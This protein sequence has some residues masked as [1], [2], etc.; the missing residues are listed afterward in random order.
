MHRYAQTNIQ[1]INQLLREGYGT[2][3]VCAVTRAYELCAVLMT[4]RFRASGKTFIA[5][6]VGTAS[7]LGSL[8]APPALIAAGLLHAVYLAGDFGGD[9]LP[10]I[11]DAKRQRVRAAVGEQVENYV[12]RYDA[13]RWTDHSIR[14]LSVALDS[15]AAT[16]RDIVLV[17]LANELE[18]HLDL[19]ILYCA[20]GRR[21]Q[22][23]GEGRCRIMVAMAEGLGF[24][25]LAAELDRAFAEVAAAS[26]PRELLGLD[27]HVSSFLIAPQ[28]YQ[29]LKD[30]IARRLASVS[31]IRSEPLP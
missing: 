19:G 3:D 29:Q 14:V 25:A 9:G 4:G 20:D 8:Q 22:V 30:G 21:S 18:E 16:E 23:T 7:I 10:G 12:S 2:A 28:S 15:M 17:R 5:H 31:K 1:L 27:P 13:L 26:I 6:L 24:P 11:S